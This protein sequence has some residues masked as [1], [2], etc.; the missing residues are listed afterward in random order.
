MIPYNKIFNNDNCDFITD[1]FYLNEH[2]L[3]W[4]EDLGIGFIKPQSN[5]ELIYDKSYWDNYRKLIDT[6][7]GKA[8][9][10]AR[11]DICKL[12]KIKPMSLIDIGIGNGQF[13]DSYKCYG[14]DINP[15][16]VEYL[17]ETK[18]Y[19]DL[20]TDNCR[21]QWLSMWDTIEHIENPKSILDKA[22]G[23]VLSTP[24]YKDMMDCVQSKHLKPEEHLWYFTVSGMIYFMNLFGF[25]CVYYSTVETKIG[26][27][28]IGSF[29]FTRTH[30]SVIM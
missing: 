14:T 28:S 29:I 30:K 17:K 20:D 12:F 11:I 13:V 19:I 4:N 2:T 27:E 8:L 1:E 21:W 9:T 25:D 24:I 6:E 22:D 18:R 7:I 26:R 10:K 5:T 16:A 23:I 15:V 3:E